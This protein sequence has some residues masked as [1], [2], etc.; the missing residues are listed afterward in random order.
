MNED[1]VIVKL[2]DGEY[3][4]GK[5]ALDTTAEIVLKDPRL[6][7]MVPTQTGEMGVLFKSVCYPWT[8]TRLKERMDIYKS[9]I[10]FTLYKDEIE[11]QFIDGYQS[12]ISG[13]QIASQAD[14]NSLNNKDTSGLII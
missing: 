1:I 13:I 10:I 12:E 14:L 5:C 4:I 2:I 3:I 9:Q 7:I 8:S 6:I 11:K